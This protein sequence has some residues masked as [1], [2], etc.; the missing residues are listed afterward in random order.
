MA[1]DF[2]ELNNFRRRSPMP[3]YQSEV[4]DWSETMT[5]DVKTKI[6]DGLELGASYDEIE[7]SEFDFD[8]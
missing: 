4:L 3:L 7:N 5:K 2:D 8:V 6:R 1:I